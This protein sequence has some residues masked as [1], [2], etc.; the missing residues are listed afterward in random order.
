M[1]ATNGARLAVAD[2]A[3]GLK[4][5]G[6]EIVA[7]E[8]LR[9]RLLTALVAGIGAQQRATR[10]TGVTGTVR[11]LAGDPVLRAQ[12]TV[13]LL[14][15]RKARQRVER[16]RSH[17]LRNAVVVLAGV[18]AASVVVAVPAVRDRILGIVGDVRQRVAAADPASAPATVTEEIVEA[19]LSTV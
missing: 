17:R 14:Q 11:R 10:Q 12:L 13:M 2:A 7:D 19:P 8:K 16:R 18:G 3:E 15:L 5:Y 4:R 6:G 1:L 9:E